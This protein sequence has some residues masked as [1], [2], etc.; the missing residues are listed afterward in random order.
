MLSFSAL[1][2]AVPEDSFTPSQQ[3]IT[4]KMVDILNPPKAEG[5]SG[6]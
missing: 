1:S 6:E 5:Q 3:S 4:G 2:F